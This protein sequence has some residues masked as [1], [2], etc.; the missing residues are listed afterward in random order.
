[1]MDRF[2]NY[3]ERIVKSNPLVWSFVSLN[4]TY[5]ELAK[6]RLERAQAIVRDLKTPPKS[7]LDKISLSG[8]SSR[9][10]KRNL[11]CRF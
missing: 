5:L 3:P 11:D 7:E 2:V 8:T 1:M 9:Q 4:M 10:S 6:K